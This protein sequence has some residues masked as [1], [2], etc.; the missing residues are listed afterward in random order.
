MMIAKFFCFIQ[1]NGFDLWKKTKIFL[2]KKKKLLHNSKGKWHS[3]QTYVF[4][5]NKAT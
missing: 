5:A 2:K 4:E 1:Q 3:F